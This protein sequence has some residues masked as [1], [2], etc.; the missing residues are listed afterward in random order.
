MSGDTHRSARQPPRQER[1]QNEF[2]R[3]NFFDVWL[4]ELAPSAELLAWAHA[5]PLTDHRWKQYVRRYRREMNRPEG[6]H[7]IEA[8]AA[9]SRHTN[10]AVGCYCDNPAR[11]HRSLLATLLKAN[12]ADVVQHGT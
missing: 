7:L 10:F 3:R 6:K 5:A 2:A 4:P 12:G 1:G 9:L 8:L 11:C